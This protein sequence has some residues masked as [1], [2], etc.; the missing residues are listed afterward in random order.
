MLK[1][2]TTSGRGLLSR[3]AIDKP[4]AAASWWRHVA[5]RD[6]NR[7]ASIFASGSRI[8]VMLIIILVMLAFILMTVLRRIPIGRG[9]GGGIAGQENRNKNKR[10]KAKRMSVHSI[11]LVDSFLSYIGLQKQKMKS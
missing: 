5:Q 3:R 2:I 7:V 6:L 1:L 9:S 4:N 8:A 11:A 10:G